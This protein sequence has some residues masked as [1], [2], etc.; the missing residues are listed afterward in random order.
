MRPGLI[1]GPHDYTERFT[2]FVRRAAQGGTMLMPDRPD[3]PEQFIHA[4]DQ[5]HFLVDSA[6]SSIPG[7]FNTVGPDEPCTLADLLATIASVAAVDL[8]VVWAD[9]EFVAAHGAQFPIPTYWPSTAGGDGL[10]LVSNARALAAGLKNRTTAEAVADILE[11][12]RDRDQ[13]AALGDGAWM[14]AAREAELLAAWGRRD[15]D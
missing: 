9:E 7:I 5:G 11:W 14:D 13:N 4:R 15:A 1:V 8:E 2:Y 10:N 12:D 3:Q 6:L